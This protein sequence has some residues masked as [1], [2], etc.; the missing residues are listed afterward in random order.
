MHSIMEVTGLREK[1]KRY[2][3]GILDVG[4]TTGAVY[5][6][7]LMAKGIPWVTSLNRIATA[8]S[9]NP[10]LNEKPIMNKIIKG[11]RRMFIDIG[12]LK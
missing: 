7:I 6:S 9:H 11:S 10:M 2:F 12:T 8:E 5:I 3:N 1:K 4:Y